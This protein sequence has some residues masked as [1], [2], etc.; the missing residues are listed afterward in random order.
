[1][2]ALLPKKVR[3][4]VDLSEHEATLLHHLADRLSVRSRADLLQQAYGSFLWILNELLAGRHVVSIDSETL[5]KLERYRELSVPAAEPLR[6]EH[7]EYLTAR[8]E[9][10]CKQLYLK[11]RNMKVGQLIYTMRAN[12]LSAEEAARDF[13]LPIQQVR[14]AEMYYHVNQ[15]LIEQENQESKQRLIDAGV[16]VES[17]YLPR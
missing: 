9:T 8:P 3:V 16:E 14:E 5:Q 7:Y 6:F 15:T 17:A 4:Q 2:A 10:G 1:M 12:H 11:G 13:D